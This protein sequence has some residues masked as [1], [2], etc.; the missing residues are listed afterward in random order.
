MA[1]REVASRDVLEFCLIMVGLL[2]LL[3]VGPLVMPDAGF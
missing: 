3:I 2:T 1:W